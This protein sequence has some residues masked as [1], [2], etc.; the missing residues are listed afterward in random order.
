MPSRGR[1][2]TLIELLVV[3]AII[4]VLI[5]LL[6]PAVQA[7]REAARR[8]SCVNNLKQIGLAVANYESS[9]GSLPIGVLGSALTD[10]PPCNTSVYGINHMTVDAFALILPDLEAAAQYN[11]INFDVS[12][13]YSRNNTGYNAKLAA[14]LCPSDLPSTPNDVA[15]GQVPM[16]QG[17]YGLN[18]GVSEVVFYGS[19]GVVQPGCEAIPFGD[20]P[21]NKNYCYKYASITD[22]LSNT[23]LVGERSR[24]K[25]EPASAFE[26]WNI[27][28]VFTGVL[29]EYRTTAFAYVVPQINAPL[30]TYDP[31]KSVITPTTLR[32]WYNN[33]GA[34]QLGNFGFRSLHPG[35]ASFVFCDGSVRFL[36][37]TINPATYRALGT[38]AYGEVI[39]ADAF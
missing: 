2:F 31:T 23:I 27:A 11:A 25:D 8:A 35:G 10:N 6:L 7:A 19:Y 38:R 34:L 36:K 4:A 16:T 13:F 9:I 20:G 21:F 33:P 30:Q 12:A 1:G 18:M 3:I 24:F 17:S 5:A 32:T 15:R 22:G 26:M 14:Y 28:G 37:Q 29:N 39:S